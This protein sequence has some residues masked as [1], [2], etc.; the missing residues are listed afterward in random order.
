MIYNIVR[1]HD[2]K[3]DRD[4]SRHQSLFVAI[5]QTQ[6]TSGNTDFKPRFDP[7]YF[8]PE[9]PD[10]RYTELHVACGAGHQTQ[11]QKAT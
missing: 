8:Q 4:G 1:L 11:P 10:E 5:Q 6:E 7:E 3:V 9:R 2:L